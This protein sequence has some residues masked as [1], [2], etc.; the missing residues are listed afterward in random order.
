MNLEK[1]KTEGGLFFY[2]VRK[3]RVF[4]TAVVFGFSMTPRPCLGLGN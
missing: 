4:F 2:E 1:T 3:T